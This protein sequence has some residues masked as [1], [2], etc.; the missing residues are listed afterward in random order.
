[1]AIYK[2]NNFYPHLQEIDLTNENTFS[3]QVN[4][5]GAMVS[6][7][8]LTISSEDNILVYENLY[9][10]VDINGNKDPIENKGFM[11]LPMEPYKIDKSN[12]SFGLIDDTLE[13]VYYKYAINDNG[14]VIYYDEYGENGKRIGFATREEA[15]SAQVYD[16]DGITI[17]YNQGVE[18]GMLNNYNRKVVIINNIDFIT[19]HPE[20][21]LSYDVRKDYCP[22]NFYNVK[23]KD[24]FCF[25]LKFVNSSDENDVFLYPFKYLDYEKTDNGY[26]MKITYNTELLFEDM[27]K[28]DCYIVLLNDKDYT[29]DVKMY[30]HLFRGDID[31]GT[32]V[33]DG[34]I[35]GSTKTVLWWDADKQTEDTLLNRKEIKEDYY[36][37]INATED[38]S[39]IFKEQLKLGRTTKGTLSVDKN[40]VYYRY[41]INDDSEKVYYDEY[42]ENGKK[43]GFKTEEEANTVKEIY[44]KD[45]ETILDDIFTEKESNENINDEDLLKIEDSLSPVCN[46]TYSGNYIYNTPLPYEVY[47]TLETGQKIKK[48]QTIQR[49]KFYNSNIFTMTDR[50]GRDYISLNPKYKD[51]SRDVDETEFCINYIAEV[52]D[53][54]DAPYNNGAWK[55]S[56][57]IDWKIIENVYID[58]DEIDGKKIFK[59]LENSNPT[60]KTSAIRCLNTYATDNIVGLDEQCRN[61]FYWRNYDIYGN[62]RTLA[63][64]NHYVS[65]R[66]NNT[67]S[68]SILNQDFYHYPFVF[69]DSSTKVVGFK[70]SILMDFYGKCKNVDFKQKINEVINFYNNNYITIFVGTDEYYAKVF[71][72]R[73]F[74]NNFYSGIYDGRQY[75]ESV[76]APNCNCLKYPSITQDGYVLF[77]TTYISKKIF[78]NTQQGEVIAPYDNDEITKWTKELITTEDDIAAF[79][80]RGDYA[81]ALELPSSYMPYQ[82]LEYEKYFSLVYPPVSISDNVVL[83]TKIVAQDL[84]TRAI[85][86]QLYSEVDV[87]GGKSYEVSGLLKISGLELTNEAFKKYVDIFSCKI[88]EKTNSSQYIDYSISDFNSYIKYKTMDGIYYDFSFKIII[89]LSF[90]EPVLELNI[91]MRVLTDLENSRSVTIYNLSLLETEND[92]KINNIYLNSNTVDTSD[93]EDNIYIH[94]VASSS[95]ASDYYK[96][97]I[98]ENNFK[99]KNYIKSLNSFEFEDKKIQDLFVNFLSQDELNAVVD[100]YLFYKKREKITWVTE[101]LGF[102][103]NINKIEVENDFDV[104]LK[105][106]ATIDLYG[107]N[108]ENTYYSFFGVRNSDINVEDIYVRFPGYQGVDFN[109][110]YIIDTKPYYK[111]DTEPAVSIYENNSPSEIPLSNNVGLKGDFYQRGNYYSEANSTNSTHWTSDISQPVSM[112]GRNVS[113]DVFEKNDCYIYGYIETFD[114]TKDGTKNCFTSI[115][116]AA[117][118]VLNY[119][120]ESVHHLKFLDIDDHILCDIYADIDENNTITL[121]LNKELNRWELRLTSGIW[122]NT[123]FSMVN[124]RDAIDSSK[125]WLWKDDKIKILFEDVY[126]NTGMVTE[127]TSFD[128][129]FGNGSEHISKPITYL[130]N[131]N[132]IPESYCKLFKVTSYDYETGEFVI[133]GGLEREILNTDRYEIWQRTVNESMTN[134]YNITEVAYQYTRLYPPSENYKD[135]AYVGDTKILKDGIKIMNN[136][137]SRV[138]IQPNVNFYSDEYNYPYLYLDNYAQRLEFPYNYMVYDDGFTIQD[139]TIET[140]DGSQWLLSYNT[141]SEVDITPGLT[142]KLY[143]DTCKSTPSNWFYGR[144]IANITMRVGEYNY[145]QEQLDKGYVRPVDFIDFKQTFNDITNKKIGNNCLVQCVDAYF[146]A[147]YD[148]LSIPIKR[149]RY[150]FYDSSMNLINDS[151]YI[152]DNHISY[153]VRGLRNEEIYLL[154]FEMEDQLGYVYHYEEKI[155]VKYIEYNTNIIQLQLTNKDSQGC[156]VGDFVT[157][158]EAN[159]PADEYGN[160]PEYIIAERDTYDEDGNVIKKGSIIKKGTIYFELCKQSDFINKLSLD[161]LADNNILVYRRNKEK[162]LSFVCKINLSKDQIITGTDESDHRYGFIDYGVYNNEYYDYV[163]ILKQKDLT[164]DSH[165]GNME[166]TYSESRCKTSFNGWILVDIEKDDNSNSYYV[167]DQVWNFKYNLESQDLTQNT[168]VSKWDTLGKYANVYIGQKNYI[169]SGLTCLLGDV[170]TYYTYNGDTFKEN[171]GYFEQTSE[172][173]N[174]DDIHNIISNEILTNNIDKYLSWKT[175]NNNGNPKLLK[176]YKGNMWIVQIMENPTV[177]NADNSQEQ[178]YTISFNWVEIMD[179]R[180]YPILGKNIS[181]DREEA[182]NVEIMDILQPWD[183]SYESED[184]FYKLNKVQ[185]DWAYNNVMSYSSPLMVSGRI[186]LETNSMIGKLNDSYLGNSVLED[187]K[188]FLYSMSNEDVE[189]LYNNKGAFMSPFKTKQLNDTYDYSPNLTYLYFEQSLSYENNS[190]DFVCCG[191]KLLNGI[192]INLTD[193]IKTARYAFA[194]TSISTDEQY[195]IIINTNNYINTYGMLDDLQ[196]DGIVTVKWGTLAEDPDLTTYAE[197]YERYWNNDKIKLDCIYNFNPDDWSWYSDPKSGVEDEV[198]YYAKMVL[199]NYSGNL[200]SVYIPKFYKLKDVNG[201]DRIVLIELSEDFNI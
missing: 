177:K 199:K 57:E 97:I 52:Y 3:C 137:N 61:C 128:I 142:Y 4:T 12:I 65:V 49:W 7:A 27:S 41:A 21:E 190:I 114:E 91:R 28:Y 38:N 22:Y 60:V 17:L 106:S 54:I 82:C 172:S 102:N 73:P 10:F 168:S 69:S 43:I 182:A 15:T 198:E 45:N 53:L 99:I 135:V 80:K 140:L 188:E 173:V 132:I 152:Y 111:D 141:I 131:K 176:D 181:F 129:N 78:P 100:Y 108:N 90:I 51:Y 165:L 19:L 72:P 2:P 121:S 98:G 166:Y 96:E 115:D 101:N 56:P 70:K 83:K 93:Y 163:V 46:V 77:D 109:G 191:M 154:H 71:T 139:R 39:D 185:D 156:V 89:P 95:T 178:V 58:I 37:E 119:Y 1:M 136:T 162:L 169:S 157:L 33:T 63:Y 124:N 40:F 48:N 153:G 75:H 74:S 189:L 86:N 30:E 196:G 127:Y 117:P 138:F 133:A 118:E 55:E 9:Q 113:G 79:L 201:I 195:Q 147:T 85:N 59:I 35:A 134:E 112:Y 88:F 200:S 170:G 123:I 174:Y 20:P 50:Y 81:T 186:T 13:P 145:I 155:I 110:N 130:F 94:T 180:K 62:I 26:N 24:S 148:Q 8:R 158:V 197:L 107:G 34:Y 103:K 192:N 64:G 104:N 87:V 122:Y 105:D 31:K 125:V 159:P 160:I 179:W 16:E 11:E 149:Y 120:Q 126:I 161:P 194:G 184:M 29:W 23:L 76:L 44:D 32:L 187:D 183:Y 66:N 42:G 171:F 146:M 144:N 175:F 36:V 150:K 84:N 164:T 14:K 193:A 143:M 167:S 116:I 18:D 67:I 92:N 5:D 47:K 25:G 68:E 151:G 6:A